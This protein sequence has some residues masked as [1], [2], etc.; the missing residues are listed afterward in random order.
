M[1]SQGSQVTSKRNVKVSITDYPKI[2]ELL[3]SKFR[4]VASSQ[5]FDHILQEKD[6]QPM[7]NKDKK[8]YDL[9]LAFI[10]DAF[11]NVWADATDFYLVAKNKKEKNG[12]QVYLDAVNY[13][14]GVAVK[15]AILTENMD[16]FVTT[17]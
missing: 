13:F 8:Q 10:Y 16:A 12:R 11:Q 3:D 6:Y 14:K 9:A 5:G 2:A 17:S 7:S 4:L 15:D 1:I